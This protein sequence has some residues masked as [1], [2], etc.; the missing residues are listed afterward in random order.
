MTTG[1]G[2]Q[3][4]RLQ[5][6][7]TCFVAFQRT[8]RIPDDGRTYP[9]PPGLGRLPV[10]S[11]KGSLRHFVVPMHR[12]EAVWLAFDAPPWHPH[13]VLIGL[14]R[15]NAVTGNPWTDQLAGDPQNYLVCPPQLWLDGV[16]VGP[17]RVRQ[18][19]ATPLGTGTTIESQLAAGEE[20]GVV[21]IIVFEP[22]PGHFPDEPPPAATT[23]SRLQSPGAVGLGA[24]GQIRQRVHADPHGIA[25][26]N[27]QDRAQAEIR[28]VGP[29]EFRTLTGEDAPPTP[30][31][32]S[33]YTEHGFPWFDVYE[34]STADLQATARMEGVRSVDQIAA[35]ESP[36]RSID[37][38]DSQITKLGRR[39]GG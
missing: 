21:R 10:R 13:A 39:N 3:S 4:D 38:P 36:D 11:Q 29:V 31:D 6:G 30:I 1:I 22:R 27:P 14:G 5:L 2:V 35:G 18:F 24:G 34:D 17:E 20:E 32:A 37:I 28:L 23:T 26:W 33:T 16:K 15:I 12:R 19:V 7:E 25:V 9:L 8:L